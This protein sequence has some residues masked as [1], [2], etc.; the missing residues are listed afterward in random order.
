MDVIDPHE[1]TNDEVITGEG[2][3]TLEDLFGDLV[4]ARGRYIAPEPNPEAGGYFRSDHFSFAKAGVPA[5]DAASGIDVVGKGGKCT[6]S[7]WKTT[8]PI[9]ITTAPPMSMI[10]PGPS[11]EGYSTWN[12]CSSWG[13]VLPIVI[14]GQPG[15]RDRSSKQSAKRAFRRIEPALRQ[16]CGIVAPVHVRKGRIGIHRY[17]RGAPGE[18]HGDVI[19]LQPRFHG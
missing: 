16:L 12:F 14:Y 11:K 1:K 2:Q 15:K 8:I 5:L 10:P 13:S 6:G 9:S 17:A 7:N 19:L 4:K 3:S 18:G